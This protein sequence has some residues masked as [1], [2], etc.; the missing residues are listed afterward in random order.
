[1][2]D[3]LV[4]AIILGS[5]PAAFLN[6]FYGVLLWIWVAY[7]NPHRFTYGIAYTF[8]VAMVLA[9]PTIAGTLFTKQRNKNVFTRET[10]LLLILWSWF[11]I[12]LFCATLNPLFSMH[13]AEG[14]DQL[15]IITKILLMIG[16]TVLLTNSPQR[17]RLLL[18]D[19]LQLW[20]VGSQGCT[21]WT[22]HQR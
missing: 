20:G 8:P 17:L 12:T 9:V 21:L 2:R 16:L 15:I 7:F 18:L 10:V 5:L 19:G 6:P 3:I 14:R 22:P 4:L 1:M 13:V 11:G